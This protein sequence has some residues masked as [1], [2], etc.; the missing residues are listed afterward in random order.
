[1]K[2]RLYTALSERILL[3][4]GGF[5]TMM[6][7]NGFTEAD[8]RSTRFA[9]HPTPL[10]GCGD[11][12]SLTQPEAVEAIHEKYL[13]AG[14]DIITSNSFN[15]NAIS[16][17]DY[18]LEGYAEEIA[19]AATSIARRAADRYTARN[20]QKPRFVAGSVGPTN[21]TLSLSAEVENPAARELSFAELVA[22]YTEQIRGLVAGGADIILIETVFDTLNAKAA[23]YAVE[24]ASC[25][26]PVMVSG[27]LAD[28]SGRTLSGQ[29]VEAFCASLTHAPLLSIG[30]NCA[31]GAHDLRQIGRAHV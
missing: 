10:K 2:N 22:A 11:L 14:A 28:R 21:R 3:L 16:L 8:Y 19:R 29:T 6:Q 26:L 15:A 23:L 20:P 13:A 25:T 12:L 31:F 24:E 18:A 27:T 4:D 9:D 17:R 5:G 7:Q 1:M 30:L